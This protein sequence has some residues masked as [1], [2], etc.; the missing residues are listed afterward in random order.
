MKLALQAP[1]L[2]HV[3]SRAPAGA[4]NPARGQAIHALAPAVVFAALL[5]NF[6]LCFL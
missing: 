5:F 6:I 3:R 2:Q 1:P 4:R